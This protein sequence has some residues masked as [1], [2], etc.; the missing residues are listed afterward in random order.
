MANSAIT[1]YRYSLLPIRSLH[2]H[3]RADFD[4][5]VEIDH[6]LVGQADA[7]RRRRRTDRVRLVRA[8]DAV[9]RRAEIHRARAQRIVDAAGHVTRQV[10]PAF[11]HLVRRRPVRPLALGA[12][13]RDA[14]PGHPLAADADG[15]AQRLT[16]AEHEI[17]PALRGADDDGAWF[18]VAGIADH[19]AGDR[20]AERGREQRAAPAA[21]L[22]IDTMR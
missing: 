12:D 21:N 14:A 4:P 20:R 5:A 10:G 6:V 22:S 8:V 1:P 16:V 7:A 15:V 19:R 18:L 9:K 3:G 2:D 13:L 17:E 11:E